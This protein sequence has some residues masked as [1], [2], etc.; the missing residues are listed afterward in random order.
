[1]IEMALALAMQPGAQECPLASGVGYVE[2]I[3]SVARRHGRPPTVAAPNRRARELRPDD[4]LCGGDMVVNPADSGFTVLLR[5]GRTSV[6]LAPGARHT[7]HDPWWRIPFPSPG[8][9]ARAFARFNADRDSLKEAVPRGHESYLPRY[10]SAACKLPLEAEPSADNFIFSDRPVRLSWTCR[11]PQER[12]TVVVTGG[13]TTRRFS[14]DRTYFGFNPRDACRGTCLVRVED[15]NGDSIFSLRLSVVD[16][17]ALD[18]EM[19]ALV[20]SDDPRAVS[21]AAMELLE[22]PQWQLAGASLLW[23]QACRFP[24]AAAAALDIYRLRAMAD[25][26]PPGGQ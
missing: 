18:N 12:F 2:Q 1:M 20:A 26:C 9:I 14:Q 7:V 17:S 10:A 15:G 22:R 19:A 8:R 6:P 3:R 5:I 4:L 21:L 23:E 16:R 13:G 25:L 24:P 11:P